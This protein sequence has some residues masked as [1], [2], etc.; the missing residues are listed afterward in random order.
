MIRFTRTRLN[1]LV[2]ALGAMLVGLPPVCVA[3]EPP[4]EKIPLRVLYAGH[5]GSPRETEFLTFLKQ[6]FRQV[7]TADLAQFA[8]KD[9]AES[10]VVLLDYDGDGFKAPRPALPNDYARPTVH[11]G[12]A[13]GLLASQLGLKTG[14]L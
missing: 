8:P 11:L 5:P 6:Y 14:Y 10:D 4:S 12:V 13:G 2:I 3:L 7:T 1:G 9:A